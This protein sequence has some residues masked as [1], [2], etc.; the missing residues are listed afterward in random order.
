MGKRKFDCKYYKSRVNKI[1]SNLV[2]NK[3]MNS[4]IKI[5]IEKGSENKQKLWPK[6]NN[7]TINKNKNKKDPSDLLT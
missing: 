4:D 1:S 7:S 6:S 2:R 3:V 5:K